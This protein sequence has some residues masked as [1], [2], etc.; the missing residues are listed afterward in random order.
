MSI[1]DL[2]LEPLQ[3]DF[4]VRALLA[5]TLA[6]VVCA[7]ISCWLVLIGWSLMGDAIAHAVFPGVVIAYTLGAPFALGALVFAGLAVG[8]IG[9][10]RSTRHVREDTAIGIVFT[11]LFALGLVLISVTP[12][13]IDLGHIVFGNVLGV[14]ADDL[15]HIAVIAGVVAV[16]V[17]VKRRD[18]TLVAFDRAHAHALGIDPRVISA[19]LL[20]LLAL[21]TVVA[22]QIVG[23][24]LVVAMLVVPGAT[25]RLLTDR[26]R[27]MLVI[28]PSLAAGSSVIGIYLSY[29]FDASPGGLVVLVQA[30]VFAAVAVGVRLRGARRR[31]RS[32]P[33][34][35]ATH[36]A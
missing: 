13:Q 35:T 29:G 21:T 3:Y 23:V 33:R 6:A 34:R 22:L 11:S 9:A 30:T 19:L 15:L 20:G 12:S 31:E 8:L 16:I 1:L 17:I 25:A 28:A 5:T 24:I 2:L 36:S 7:L 27:R 26:L 10:V 4:M 32:I 18:L 14:S